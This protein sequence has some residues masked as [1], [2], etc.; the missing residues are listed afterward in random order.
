MTAESTRMPDVSYLLPEDEIQ[1]RDILS[2]LPKT[3]RHC[4]ENEAGLYN[5]K[6]LVLVSPGIYSSRARVSK[7]A[8][9]SRAATSS[10]K[11]RLRNSTRTKTRSRTDI[12]ANI[13]AKAVAIITMPP[14]SVGVMTVNGGD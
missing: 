13:R 2:S 8:M 11:K 5:H 12:R 14:W 7:L 3:M 9:D 1:V 4:A 6:D 10:P